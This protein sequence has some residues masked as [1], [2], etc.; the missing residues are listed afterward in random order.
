MKDNSNLK[1]ITFTIMGRYFLILKLFLKSK[2]IFK[3]PPKHELVI[4]DDESFRDLE[5]FIHNYNF[6]V[7]WLSLWPFPYPVCTY[8]NLSQ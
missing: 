7:Y 3:N 2:F 8:R 5:N 1:K 6:F 4:F